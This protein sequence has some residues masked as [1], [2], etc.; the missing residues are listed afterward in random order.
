V[1]LKKLKGKHIIFWA[2][3]IMLP[4]VAI[5]ILSFLSLSTFMRTKD[6]IL[7]KNFPAQLNMKGDEI[8]KEFP[9]LAPRQRAGQFLGFEFDP[10]MGFSGLD[11]L[12]WYGDK[13][14]DLAD[15]FI[16]VTFG[17][18]TTVQENWPK[19]LIEYAKQ[20]GVKDDIV[21]LNAGLWGYMTFNEKI[22]F[23]SWII[24]MLTSMGA[25]PD[26]VLTM[27]GVNDIWYRILGYL[28]YKN[29]NAPKWFNQYHGYHQHHDSDMRIIRTI[30]GSTKQLFANISKEV[31]QT[32]IRIM[33][34][35]MKVVQNI[36]KK[37]IENSDNIV[38]DNDNEPDTIKLDS[39]IEDRIIDGYN[40]SLLDFY[41]AADARDIQ[42]VAYLQPILLKQYYPYEIPP[43]FHYPNIN[44]MGKS[45]YR[46]NRHFSRLAC[47]NIIQTDSLYKKTEH[48]YSRLNEKH[49]G[50][51][52]N[53]IDIFKKENCREE[54][55]KGDAIHYSKTGSKVIARNIIEDLINKRILTIDNRKDELLSTRKN[56]RNLTEDFNLENLLN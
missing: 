16:I 34:Y 36:I 42:F 13:D 33:P 32:S 27:D 24:P 29:M 44:Y 45:L 21:V 26:L 9:T 38:V 48:M 37:K 51:F 39:P 35:T 1:I 17:G 6:D 18:S 7:I 23:S 25:K 22:Y 47:N 20:S 28:E 14:N 50:H 8:R 49:S 12:E 40:N 4:F 3:I 19:Y 52:K 2:L 41:A 10:A 54:V 15:K 53:I 11:A 56:R 43:S 55:F 30:S 5:E 46:T 31:F